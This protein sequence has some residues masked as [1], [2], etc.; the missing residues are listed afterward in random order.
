MIFD[1]LK[2]FVTYGNFAWKLCPSTIVAV[3]SFYIGRFTTLGGVESGAVILIFSMFGFITI[4][5]FITFI[6]IFMVWKRGKNNE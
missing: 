2:H 5:M 6:S 1:T 3:V 4:D